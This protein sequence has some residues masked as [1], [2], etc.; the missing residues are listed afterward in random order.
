MS[1]KTKVKIQISVDTGYD[2]V[3]AHQEMRLVDG[4]SKEKIVEVLVDIA[5]DIKGSINA[6]RN[7]GKI[8]AEKALECTPVDPSVI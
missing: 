1:E 8:Q 7:F 5:N 4:F 2:T 6:G 3:F